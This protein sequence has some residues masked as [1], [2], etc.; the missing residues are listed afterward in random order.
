MDLG[1]PGENLR[2]ANPRG[3]Q[4]RGAP[5]RSA[6]PR[7][8]DRRAIGRVLDSGR[9]DVLHAHNWIANSALAVA[10]RSHCPLVL[11]LHDYSH[12]CGH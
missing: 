1:S 12:V 5:A 8:G 11:T 7:P 2:A 4:R 6:A 10:H 3:V 9:F